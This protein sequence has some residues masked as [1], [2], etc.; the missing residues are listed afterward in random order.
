MILD[1]T[2]YHADVYYN[3]KTG[4]RIHAPF[5]DGIV[6]DV[7]YDGSIKAF[8]FLLNTECCV[9]ID[10]C[11]KF[12]SD[13]TN[14]EL[15]ISRGMINGL[16]KEFS[17]KTK[18]EQK[19]LFQRIMA[20]P[21]MHIDCTNTRVNGKNTYVFVTVAPDGEVLYF[22]RHKKG[23]EGVKGTPPEDY[24]GI[25]VHDHEKTFYKYGSSHQECLAHVKRYLKDASE[26]EKGK[27][28]SLKMLSLLKEM[29]HYRNGLS[30][31]EECSKE[32]VLEF[33]E[34]YLEI[35]DTAK[36]EY[37]D[38]PPSDHYK[39]GFNLYKRLYEYKV[40]LSQYFRHKKLNFFSLHNCKEIHLLSCKSFIFNSLWC[41]VTQ[42][43]VTSFAI[44]E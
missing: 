42:S 35:L 27:T 24:Q 39:D 21:V 4:E 22:A 19:E 44:V 32:K 36:T 13:L 16:G 38:E 34:K 31:L 7:N 2:E 14:G 26:N 30:P 5:P 6:N 11:R 29:I 20:S 43:T 1:V 3:S 17:L 28:W 18:Q 10:K 33:E 23:H 9:S 37:E 15:K 41:F 25:L 12:L 40:D 8:L